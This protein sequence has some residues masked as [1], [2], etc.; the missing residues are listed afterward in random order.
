M[1][2]VWILCPLVLLTTMCR[3]DETPQYS[4]RASKAYADDWVDVAKNITIS[5]FRFQDTS[6]SEILAYIEKASKEGDTEGKGVEI[7]IPKEFEAEF[8]SVANSTLTMQLADNLNIMT[9]FIEVPPPE[10]LYF[11]TAPR[12]I[13]VIPQRALIRYLPH[14]T[15]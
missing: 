7:F 4:F 14:P 12:K 5:R 11:P 13:A 1:N 8:V 3:A 2:A 6:W 9:V 15:K 10:W